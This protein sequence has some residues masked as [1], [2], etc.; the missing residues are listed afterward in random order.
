MGVDGDASNDAHEWKHVEEPFSFACNE[1]IPGCADGLTVD[2][3][4]AND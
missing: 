4:Y 3:T 1:D 2:S